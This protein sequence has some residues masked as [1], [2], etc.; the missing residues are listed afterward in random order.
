[1]AAIPTDQFRYAGRAA[2][3]AAAGDEDDTVR[4][5]NSQNL[6]ARLQATGDAVQ[7]KIYPGISHVKLI[8]ALAR[9]I[10]FLAP[11]KK[12][13]MAFIDATPSRMP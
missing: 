9:P 4:P 3:A 7:L 10:T 5:R 11:V 2:D 6:A 12:D 8:G 1:M 13:V